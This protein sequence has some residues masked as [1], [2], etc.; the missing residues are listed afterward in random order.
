MRIGKYTIQI[1]PEN[2]EVK[3]IH[4]TGRMIIFWGALLFSVIVTILYLS[5]NISRLIVDKAEYT[6]LK[7]K[8][9]HLENRELE[10]EKLNS[11]MKKFYD[12]AYK[13]NKSLGLEISLEEFFEAEKERLT[14]ESYALGEGGTMETEAIRLQDFVPNILPTMEGWI[15]KK[16]SAGHK[17]IDISLKE[18]TSLYATMEGIVIFTGD[19]EYLGT[20]LEIR[21]DEGFGVIYSHLSEILV[22]KGEKVKK[23]Q[24]IALSGNSGRSDAPHLHY[25]VQMQG[26]WV[27]PI[28]YLLIRR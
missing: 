22:R 5:V 19:R 8:I 3:E 28:D 15:S 6:L 24:L 17:A 25:G 23:N 26:K 7:N 14:P 12:F 10:I 20:T 27:N 21:N 13:L 9:A 4:L 18:G 11:R 16:F 2:G 1:V